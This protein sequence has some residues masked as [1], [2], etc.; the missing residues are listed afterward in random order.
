MN[1]PLFRVVYIIESGDFAL[2]AG[3]SVGKKRFRKATDRNRIRRLMREAW[4]LQSIP[5]KD[6]L[7]ARGRK[8]EVFLIFT[9][10]E[11]PTLSVVKD[12]IAGIL[13]KLCDDRTL[14]LDKPDIIG[15]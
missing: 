2:Q 7:K 10:S 5:L 13:L 8:S 1:F 4:R 12:G 15:Q 3:F 11:V 9:G 6:K 14:N